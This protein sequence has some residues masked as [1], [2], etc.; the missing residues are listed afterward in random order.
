MSHVFMKAE[1]ETGPGGAPNKAGGPVRMC[2]LCRARLPKSELTRFALSPEGEA[3]EDARQTLP[4]RGVYL[5]SSPQCRE[6]WL[7]GASRRWG[8]KS[9]NKKNAKE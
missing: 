6:K 1:P 4:G 2:A 9:A 5:C 3:R 8:P 7:R